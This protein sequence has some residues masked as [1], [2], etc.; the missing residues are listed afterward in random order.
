MAMLL[1]ILSVESMAQEKLFKEAIKNGLSSNGCYCFQNTKNKAYWVDDVLD[2]AREHGYII[3]RC[4]DKNRVRF[5]TLITQVEELWFVDAENYPTYVFSALSGSSA[6]VVRAQNTGYIFLTRGEKVYKEVNSFV[7]VYAGEKTVFDHYD[8]LW[9]GSVSN[10]YIDGSGVAFL[11]LSGGRYLRL[12]GTFSKGFP[13]SE[14]DVRY[15]TKND[16]SKAGVK[17]EEIQSTK[18]AEIPLD[19]YAHNL[20]TTDDVLKKAVLLRTEEMYNRDVARIEAIYDNVKKLSISNYED[21]PVDYFVVDFITMYQTA[22]YD[23]KNVLPKAM[24][25]NDAFYVVEALKMKFREH[26][27]GYSLWSLLT[28]FYDW[29]DKEEEQDRNLLQVGLDKA[30]SGKMN[31]KYGLGDFFGQAAERLYQKKLDF[32]RK[33]SEDIDAYNSMVDRERANRNERDAQL[34]KEIDWDR[35]VSPSGEL[36]SGLLEST[37]HYEKEGEIKFKSGSDYVTYNVYYYDR[38][39]QELEGFKI[40]YASDDIRSNMGDKKY[41]TYKSMSQMVEEILK[42]RY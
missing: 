29:L 20:E 25:I 6:D 27:Y 16:M 28:L 23:P 37:W 7:S 41:T 40:L 32:E 18:Y 42:A 8:A 5:G 11:A 2:Y 36:T 31:S 39:G 22:N 19:S 10:G 17:Q 24:E 4:V 3:L 14:V 1:P 15:V 34:S 13:A 38:N 30:Q 33:I 21:F 26:Y 9:T 35:S 12:E